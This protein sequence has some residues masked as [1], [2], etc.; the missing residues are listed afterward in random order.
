MVIGQGG[1]RDLL[2]VVTGALLR[3]I[4]SLRVEVS[5]RLIRSWRR[6]ELSVIEEV[7]RRYQAGS[8]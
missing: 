5:R 1:G 2:N 4:L 7:C 8:L 3:G 6:Q